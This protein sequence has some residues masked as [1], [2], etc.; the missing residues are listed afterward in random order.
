MEFVL[1]F[2]QTVARNSA[3]Q[4]NHKTPLMP[5][6]STIT[7]AKAEAIIRDRGWSYRSLGKRLGKDPSHIYHVVKGTRISSP[8]LSQI[9]KLPT[10][11]VT[12]K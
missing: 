3:T 4:S 11:K 5:T 12:A 9:A 2:F 7:P 6:T 8:V 1:L 10:R